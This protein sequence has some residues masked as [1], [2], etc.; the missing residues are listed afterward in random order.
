[1][2]KSCD[3]YFGDDLVR[4]TV[5]TGRSIT[6]RVAASEPHIRIGI[7]PG[8]NLDKAKELY[9][10]HIDNIHRVIQKLSRESSTRHSREEYTAFFQHTAL[11]LEHWRKKMSMPDVRLRMKSMTSR[12]GSCI[13]AKKIICINSRLI[14][15]PAECLDYVIIHELAH[16]THP[17]HS[18]DF[19]ALVAIYCPDW[20]RFRTQLRQQQ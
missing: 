10:K 4:I 8:C 6:L 3:L 13:P 1:M 19:W 14:D 20:K 15:H 5:R 9:Y 16:L 2:Q 18:S 17:N 12:W 11:R 7:P